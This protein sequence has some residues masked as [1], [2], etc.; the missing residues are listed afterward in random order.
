MPSTS[1]CAIRTSRPST[2]LGASPIGGAVSLLA[3][4]QRGSAELDADGA[5]DVRLRVDERLLIDPKLL[6][7]SAVAEMR[8]AYGSIHEHFAGI[9]T[10]CWH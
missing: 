4:F 5:F 7:E 10:L 6:D 1:P 2:D 3:L 8:G 9:L